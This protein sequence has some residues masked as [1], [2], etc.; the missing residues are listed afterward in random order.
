GRA[1]WRDGIA[2]EATAQRLA[3]EKLGHHERHAVVRREIVDREDVGM[4]ER[5]DGAR[6][7]LEP[8]ERRGVAGEIRGQDLDRHLAPEARI[9]RPVDLAH[10]SRAERREDLVRP[11]TGA[12]GKAHRGLWRDSTFGRPDAWL[13]RSGL[14]SRP[15]S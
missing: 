12:R 10:S 3:L 1:A 7:P 5:G 9:A 4:R 2:V 14:H 13:A 6:L 11:E 8:F 15:Q